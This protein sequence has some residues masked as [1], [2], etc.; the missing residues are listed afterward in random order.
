M[1]APGQAEHPPQKF[2]RDLFLDQSHKDRIEEGAGQPHE[3]GEDGKG[4]EGGGRQ[5]AGGHQNDAQ[6][7]DGAEHSCHLIPKTAPEP[8]DHGACQHSNGESGLHDRGGGGISAEV[9]HAHK[10][11][12]GGHRH[13]GY[14]KK[15]ANQAE[16]PQ[17]AVRA[18][19]CKPL[20]RVPPDTQALLRL[21]HTQYR[22][23]CEKQ[24][25][26][27][28]KCSQRIRQ[29]DP[30]ERQS[31]IQRGG[32]SRGEQHRDRLDALAPTGAAVNA[33]GGAIRGVTA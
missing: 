25:A 10:G 11:E 30:M 20:F 7:E 21:S 26:D 32:Q 19:Y 6:G 17:P 9:L 15:R 22:Q 28:K 14:G 5:Q 1:M 8:Q 23:A 2:R 12:Q 33:S 4:P 24:S 27:G 29:N 31:G 3:Q 18:Q 16:L 13:E